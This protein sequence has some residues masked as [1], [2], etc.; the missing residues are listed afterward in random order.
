MKQRTEKRERCAETR[1]A[2]QQV[3][4]GHYVKHEDMK[5]WLFSWGTEH[6]LPPPKWICEKEHDDEALCR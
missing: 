2:D 4:S 5:A 3:E 1:Q 6:D